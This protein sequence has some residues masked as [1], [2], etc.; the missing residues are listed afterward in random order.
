MGDVVR[1]KTNPSVKYVIY[2]D[3]QSIYC[4]ICKHCRILSYM[5]MWILSF[6]F[7][8]IATDGNWSATNLANQVFVA[9]K[10]MNA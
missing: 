6:A 4:L 1:E 5:M 9:K 2:R 7:L 3:F 8:H 10:T